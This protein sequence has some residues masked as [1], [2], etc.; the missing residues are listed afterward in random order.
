MG[1]S[2]NVNVNVPKYKLAYVR[3]KI[4]QR[5]PDCLW[6]EAPVFE[7]HTVFRVSPTFEDVLSKI[8]LL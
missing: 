6:W 4:Y 3:V 8:I 1:A 5:V 7:R 2:V